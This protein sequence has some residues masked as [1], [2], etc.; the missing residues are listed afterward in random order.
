MEK[1]AAVSIDLDEVHHYRAIHGLPFPEQG[2]RAARAV[3]EWAVP[4]ALAFAKRRDLVL[5]FFVVGDD[6]RID[7]NADVLK[8]AISEG[9][10]VES[11]SMS[12]PYDLVRLGRDAIRREIEGSFETIERRLGKRPQG[13]R[14]PG[15]TLSDDVLDVLEEAGALFDASLLPSPAYYVAKLAA[16]GAIF[17]TGR[18]SSSIVG[19]A[20]AQL[21]PTE[22][23]RPGRPHWIRGT[24]RLIEIPMR[25]TPGAR[26]PVIGTS[27]GA[28]GPRV[29]RA[30]VRGC[31]AESTFSLELHGM[32]FLD[33]TD[34]L[35]DL[36]GHVTELARPFEARREALDAALEEIGAA[37]FEL[38]TLREIAIATARREH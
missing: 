21:G 25:V 12:H 30:L 2:G 28:V 31:R 33:R 8:G 27:L 6:L 36:V 20:R 24:R 16:L 37:G 23:Y 17:T 32:D 11:H 38:T 18:R 5:T 14:A 34:G 1:L 26:L 3:F 35:D 19:P 13:F 4:R 22:P 15:Y 7:A 9:H 29:A 10:V